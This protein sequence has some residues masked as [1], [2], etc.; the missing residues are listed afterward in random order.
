MSPLILTKVT[1]KR[2]NYCLLLRLSTTKSR[3]ILQQVATAPV[4]RSPH[5]AIV[6]H[7]PPPIRL[8]QTICLR[9]INILFAIFLPI[10]RALTPSCLLPYIWQMPQ[11]PMADLMTRQQMLS[12]TIITLFMLT[13]S[14]LMPILISYIPNRNPCLSPIRGKIWCTMTI[15][16]YQMLLTTSFDLISRKNQDIFLTTFCL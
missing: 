2:S 15:K 6:T 9:I 11:R 4:T 1:I 10:P 14:A 7:S 12:V 8:D 5:R 13:M 3:K 16:K